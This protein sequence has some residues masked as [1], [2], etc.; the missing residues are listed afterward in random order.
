MALADRGGRPTTDASRKLDLAWMFRSGY[1]EEGQRYYRQHSLDMPGQSIQFDQLS[2]DHDPAGHRRL[3][4][5]YTRGSG[6]DREDVRQTV[7][8][9][10]TTCRPM[11]ASVGG[12]SAP[13]PCPRW[14]TLRATAG[15]RFASRQ[16]AAAARLSVPA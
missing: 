14:Q 3:E 7:R 11:A 1:A 16:A 10:H 13:P 4:L 6:D 8:L 9:W 2:I 15:D 12:C 5:S